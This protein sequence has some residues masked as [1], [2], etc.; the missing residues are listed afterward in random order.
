MKAKENAGLGYSN[1]IGGAT[2]DSAQGIM[3]R[4][5][6]GDGSVLLAGEWDGVGRISI[7][8]AST[9]AVPFTLLAILE[10][11]IHGG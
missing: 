7:K 5:L 9:E 8:Q 6:S 3:R 10:E 4:V 2:F 11:T 1:G